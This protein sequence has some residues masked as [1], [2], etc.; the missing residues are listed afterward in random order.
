MDTIGAYRVIS[1]QSQTEVTTYNAERVDTKDS[2][3]IHELPAPPEQ[4]DLVENILAVLD[5][6]GKARK[7][8]LDIFVDN[9]KRYV[10]TSPLPS[11]QSLRRWTTAQLASQS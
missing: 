2:V 8:I 4:R 10:V 7:M 6:G 1:I 5:R 11:G 9:E 3:L